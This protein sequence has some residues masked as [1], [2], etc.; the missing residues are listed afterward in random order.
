MPKR[1]CAVQVLPDN[2][3]ILVADKFGDVYSLPLIAATIDDVQPEGREK[4]PPANTPFKP[5]ASEATVHSQRNRQALAAQMNQKNFTPKKEVLQFEHQL[6]LGHVSMLTDLKYLTREVEG[7]QRG[8]I[9]TSDRDEHIRISRAPPQA[10]IIEGFCL[11]HKEFINKI[12]QIENTDLLISGGGDDW[13]GIWNWQTYQLLRK[14]DLKGLVKEV[15]KDAEGKIAVSGIWSFG[16]RTTL[17]TDCVIAIACEKVAALFL[18]S[19]QA[20][21]AG[22]SSPDSTIAST[23]VSLPAAPLDVTAIGDQLL[24]SVDSRGESTK[25]LGAMVVSVHDSPELPVRCGAWK[26]VSESFDL[27]LLNEHPS[28]TTEASDK[29][30]DALLYTVANLRKRRDQEVQD[31]AGEEE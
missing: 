15:T 29:E 19:R 2:T 12:C 3:T 31:G 23:T 11:G 20:L 18:I 27:N 8:Y 22:A 13:L 17:G 21:E 14:F 16:I 24:V 7:N 28:L 4:E 25:R 30:L 5:S 6:Q 9:V 10:H 26:P 1:P